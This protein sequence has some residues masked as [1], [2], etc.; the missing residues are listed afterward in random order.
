MSGGPELPINSPKPAT[1]PPPASTMQAIAVMQSAIARSVSA[2][3]RSPATRP[4]VT[5]MASAVA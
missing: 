2:V 4:S 3:A 5:F 1:V